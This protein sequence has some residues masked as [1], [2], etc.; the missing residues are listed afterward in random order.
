MA[1]DNRSVVITLKLKN[2]SNENNNPTNTSAVQNGNDKNSTAKAVAVFAVAQMAELA[3]AE[4]VA[5]GEY[6]WNKSLTLN[7]DYV[8]QRSKNI[9]TTQINRGINAISN[10]VSSTASGAAIGGWVG[11]IVGAVV[12][13]LT[14]GV[15]IARSN[16]Q[17]QDQQN[18]LLKQMD[19]QLSFTRARVGFSLKAGSIGEDL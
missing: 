12:G 9:I 5:W 19:A 7:D 2:E 13:T 6:F 3:A 11:A 10:I 15:D 8:G 4:V 14:T 16:I 17:G 1:A 18:I